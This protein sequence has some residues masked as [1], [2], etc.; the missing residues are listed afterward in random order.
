[1]VAAG[2][3]DAVTL[4]G[5]RDDVR[6]IM[7]V[8]AVVLSL[9]LYPEAFGRTVNE[10]LALRVPVAGYAHGGVGEQLTQHFPAGLVPPGAVDA[11]AERL[12]EWSVTPPSMQAVQAY[13]LQDMLDNTL[14][15][16]RDLVALR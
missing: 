5:F 11:M 13:A 6:E 15:L 12:F 16:Y 4:T 3:V 10:A 2:L 1:M 7:S 14:V 9:S 8:S